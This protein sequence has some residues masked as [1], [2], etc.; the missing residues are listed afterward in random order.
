[1]ARTSHRAALARWANR[2][3]E[4]LKQ[5]SE[6]PALPNV[7]ASAGLAMKVVTTYARQLV[8]K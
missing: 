2:S 6:V 1:V 8:D 7:S 5:R 4:A 3:R